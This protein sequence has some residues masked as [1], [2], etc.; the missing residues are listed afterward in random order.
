MKIT[1]ISFFNCS[2]HLSKNHHWLAV[3]KNARGNWMKLYL[4]YRL[5]RSR[6][7]SLI[8]C[9]RRHHQRKHKFHH[10]SLSHRQVVH[11]RWAINLLPHRNRSVLRLLV[12]QVRIHV[13]HFSTLF[14]AWFLFESFQM[15]FS[16]QNFVSE[17]F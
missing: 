17:L 1:E 6:K 7:H 10:Q 15:C 8:H 3:K 4:V 9:F 11:R 16:T 13:S 12:C 5:P 2:H 14:Y